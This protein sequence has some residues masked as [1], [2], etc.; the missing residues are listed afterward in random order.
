M[1]GVSCPLCGKEAERPDCE[2]N[3]PLW[4]LASWDSDT[5]EWVHHSLCHWSP[6]V[7][8]SESERAREGHPVYGNIM[9]FLRSKLKDP[10]SPHL[11]RTTSQLSCG[12]DV[13]DGHKDW[14]GHSGPLCI[15][16]LPAGQ[17]MGSRPPS[18]QTVLPK[19]IISA[20]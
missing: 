15:F 14:V 17:R 8:A 5:V 4:S 19:N 7:R 6:F 3:V 11:L 9:V 20:Q 13:P 18:T 1:H 2:R 12:G 10:H 16:T